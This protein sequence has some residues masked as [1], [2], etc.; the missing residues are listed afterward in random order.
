MQKIKVYEND[1]DFIDFPAETAEILLC[2]QLLNPINFDYI[3]F[4]VNNF[5]PNWLRTEERKDLFKIARKYYEVRETYPSKATMYQIF[6]NKRYEAKE[7]KL[8]REYENIVNFNEAEL[9]DKLVVNTIKAFIKSKSI[10]FAILDNVESIENTGE[11]GDLLA[12]FEKIIQL[13]LSDD[14]GIEYFE[15]IDNHIKDLLNKQNK[16]KF[17]LTDLDKYTYGGL[18]SDDTC[19]FIIMA[20]PGLGKSMLMANMAYNWIMQ[21]KKVLIIS[22][23]MSENMYS[24]RFDALF[25]DINP[26]EIQNHIPELR[27][28]VKGVK[29][30]VPNSLLQIKEFPTGTLTSAML[31][32]YL[33]KLKQQKNFVPE[34]IFVDYLNIMKPNGSNAN[35]SL[36]EKG[37]RVAEDLRAISSEMKI[38][39]VS[40]VQSNRQSNGRRI[41]WRKHR[42]VKC[43]RISRHYC[44]S[45]CINGTVPTRRRARNL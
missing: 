30:G 12:K 43:C 17:N 26:N 16:V 15:N 14:L 24:K 3:P 19:L 41:C 33:K 29:A 38:P 42:Y 22:L 5:E 18:P 36:Y 28:R 27:K 8:L 20:Q 11:I 25:T 32:Q 13:D 10:Y 31:K 40:A 45:R 34:I 1:N 6:K 21:N 37:E 9:D 39:V 23:E 7:D 44:N 4:I 35:M 2:K